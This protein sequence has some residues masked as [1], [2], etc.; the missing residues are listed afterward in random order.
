MPPGRGGRLVL[1]PLQP[2]GWTVHSEQATP[3]GG[4]PGQLSSGD[5]L[6]S[7]RGVSRQRLQG[8]RLSEGPSR[9]LGREEGPLGT[10]GETEARV[11]RLQ[12]RGS[13]CPRIQSLLFPGP[14]HRSGDPTPTPRSSALKQSVRA[15]GPRATALK[16]AS[17]RTLMGWEW[18]GPGVDDALEG[19]SSGFAAEH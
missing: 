5:D 17:P 13:S 14:G 8:P 3:Q 19:R 7:L 15:A 10:D 4:D 2:P 11:A 16:D 9:P 18:E 1:G 12:D 6:L